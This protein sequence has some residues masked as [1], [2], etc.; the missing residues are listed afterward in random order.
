MERELEENIEQKPYFEA[1]PAPL[2]EPD[3]GTR[4][5]GELEKQSYSY[6][7]KVFEKFFP[8]IDTAIAVNE[9]NHK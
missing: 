5:M 9:V 1:V 2:P 4:E 6:V 3:E 7:Y 8:A